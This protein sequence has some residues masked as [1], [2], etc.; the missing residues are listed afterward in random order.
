[1]SRLSHVQRVRG[2]YKALLKLH[3]GLPI[4]LQALGN[5]YMK[6]EFKRHKDCEPEFVPT[7]MT[8]WTVSYAIPFPTAPPPLPP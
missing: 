3:R 4:E 2:L 1:M 8:E 6:S 5:E 7:F